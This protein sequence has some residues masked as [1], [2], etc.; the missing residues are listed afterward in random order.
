MDFSA[1]PFVLPSSSRFVLHQDPLP[2]CLDPNP[3]HPLGALPA[4]GLSQLAQSR[5]EQAAGRAGAGSASSI[6]C[7]PDNIP[8]T[9]PLCELL[10]HHLLLGKGFLDL[11]LLCATPVMK[12][13][14][15][16]CPALDR[17]M[18]GSWEWDGNS[19]KASTDGFICIIPF[20]HVETL[21]FP[22]MMSDLGSLA[23]FPLQ[24]GTSTTPG[25]VSS[26]DVQAAQ[27]CAPDV[28]KICPP[29][30]HIP[31]EQWQE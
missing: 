1:E 31:W 28:G 15:Q 10:Q 27:G 17:R 7:H 29:S 22:G 25:V 11:L 24:Q 30:L 3:S 21:L 12:P 16:H 19:R 20:E 14:S 4:A 2:G 18:G 13:V 6:P 23:G 9:Q 8:G 26:G 5:Q